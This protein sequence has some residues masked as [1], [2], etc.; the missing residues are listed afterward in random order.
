MKYFVYFL[1]IIFFNSLAF[2]YKVVSKQ[3]YFITE[4][5]SKFDL[6]LN[7]ILLIISLCIL[8]YLIF[9]KLK[10]KLKHI[11]FL[12]TISGL[13]GFYTVN[14]IYARFMLVLGLVIFCIVIIKH[15]FKV[16]RSN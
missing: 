2:F 15:I 11:C 6:Y 4:L 3:K 5:Y 10:D 16:L 14:D 8:L 13:I 7:S 12:T 1:Y 9:F